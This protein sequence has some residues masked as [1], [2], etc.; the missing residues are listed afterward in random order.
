M[1]VKVLKIIKLS[2]LFLNYKHLRLANK[3]IAKRRK[4]ATKTK[5]Y[6]GEQRKADGYY[7][8]SVIQVNKR[9]LCYKLH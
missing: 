6:N 8:L 4:L 1:Y 9:Y 3:Y 7:I 5:K 2:L